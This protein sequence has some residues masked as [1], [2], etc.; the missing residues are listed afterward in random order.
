MNFALD[1]LLFLFPQP[2]F[3]V[4]LGIL[5]AKTFCSSA[6]HPVTTTMSATYLGFH[7]LSQVVFLKDGYKISLTPHGLLQCDLVKSW[8]LILLPLNLGRSQDLFRLLSHFWLFC[9]PMDY[10]PPG[11]S[12][13]GISRQ[14]YWNGLPFPSPEDLPDPGIEFAF[15]ALIGGFFTTE[16][17][18]KPHDLTSHH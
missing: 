12:V 8:S 2:E 11:F 7:L 16:P 10:I 4:D 3:K 5:S 17:P 1:P 6:C 15:P 9:D 13:H 14:E 18:R